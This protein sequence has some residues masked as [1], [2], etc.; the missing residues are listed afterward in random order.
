MSLHPAVA[1]V[2]A[3]SDLN[4]MRLF[5]Q[6]TNALTL[7]GL[8]PAKIV[9]KIDRSGV[10]VRYFFMGQQSDKIPYGA[11]LSP[12]VDAGRSKYFQCRV[13]EG[14]SDKVSFWK[15]SYTSVIPEYTDDIEAFLASRLSSESNAA[16]DPY[17]LKTKTTDTW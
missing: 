2:S 13:V 14:G 15:M 16:P 5:F 11:K 10:D 4:L 12:R 17:E 9:E 6:V 8:E 3:L 7:R 1:K